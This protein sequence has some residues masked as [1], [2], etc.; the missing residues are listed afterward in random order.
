M[1]SL[2]S[3]NSYWFVTNKDVDIW[4]NDTINASYLALV[5]GGEYQYSKEQSASSF[6]VFCENGS[7]Y[8]EKR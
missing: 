3:Y 6:T 1:S 8:V 7:K 2:A 4:F 5:V